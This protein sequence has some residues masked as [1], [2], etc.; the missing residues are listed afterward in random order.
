MKVSVAGL[1]K[2]NLASRDISVETTLQDTSFNGDNIR[3]LEPVGLNGVIVN[4][5]GILGLKG[6]L[7]VKVELECHR[8]SKSFEYSVEIDIDEHFIKD[9]DT[10][11]DSY[12]YSGNEID[13]TPMVM[14]N[15]FTNM[16]LKILC[17]QDCK[18]LCEV[19]GSDRNVRECGCTVEDYDPRLE[20]L[21]KL[22]NKK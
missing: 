12:S 5:D 6:R 3:F 21:Q 4:E 1:I 2:N 7:A 9:D 8:C 18:G 13:L 19:C 10:E 17:K 22:K 20:V 16:P 11:G 15:I 14:D